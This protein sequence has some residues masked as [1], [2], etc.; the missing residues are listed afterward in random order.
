MKDKI[1]FEKLGY[2]SKE[3]SSSI[4]NFL[5]NLFYNITFSHNQIE[6]E[7]I[8]KVKYLSDNIFNYICFLVINFQLL[9]NIID[10][11]S[12]IITN[13]TVADHS[14]INSILYFKFTSIIRDTSMSYLLYFLISTIIFV[15]LLIISILYKLRL[16]YIQSLSFIIFYILKIFDKIL[17]LPILELLIKLF[18]NNKLNYN[19]IGYA[20]NATFVIISFIIVLT[21]KYI[22][23][24]YLTNSII[25]DLNNVDYKIINNYE[26]KELILSIV[27][28]LINAS[29]TFTYIES[30]HIYL[31]LSFIH[32]IDS[33]FNIPYIKIYK[34]VLFMKIIICFYCFMILI[35]FYFEIKN[36][37]VYFISCFIILIF[38]NHALFT[39]KINKLVFTNQMPKISNIHEFMLVINYIKN[40]FTVNNKTSNAEVQGFI[41]NMNIEVVEANLIRLDKSHLPF[42]N[43]WSSSNNMK[44]NVYKNNLFVFL[45][46]YQVNN[47]MND[48][49]LL[50][51]LSYFMLVYIE[52]Y[53]KSIFY[54]KKAYESISCHQELFAYF[55]MKKLLEQ[56]LIKDVHKSIEP[57]YHMHALDLREF[58]EY[59]ILKDSFIIKFQYYVALHNLFWM[60]SRNED[61]VYENKD[62]TNDI[63]STK[64]NSKKNGLVSLFNLVNELS[65]YHNMLGNIY[66]E[67]NLINYAWCDLWTLYDNFLNSIE[68]DLSLLNKLANHYAEYNQFLK[69][70][71]G[72][73]VITSLYSDKDST[74]IVI[75]AEKEL[76]GKIEYISSNCLRI[77]N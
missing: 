67:M 4:V 32:L 44:D 21:I 8:N 46:E 64:L 35:V 63:L 39:Y 65:S 19:T 69:K 73:I 45:F 56:N 43:E 27:I 16:I 47:N 13:P 12:H 55:K 31:L 61:E 1:L 70:N 40:N 29:N 28:V 66:I 74:S 33:Y 23:T 72:K 18:N 51:N 53:V 10:K 15:I 7:S 62:S 58:F 57:K 6:R 3:S 36:F 24:V 26:L 52:H 71:L 34:L 30:A 9:A 11:T 48:F 41:I 38:L 5:N 20:Q 75:S 42:T 50:L 25:F 60:I 77:F 2:K 76:L 22:T 17:F 37:V 59:E 54:L 49:N 68:F 14:L